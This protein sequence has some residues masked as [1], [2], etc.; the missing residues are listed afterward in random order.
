MSTSRTR[1]AGFAFQ[2]QLLT[3]VWLMKTERKSRNGWSSW[4]PG[5]HTGDLYWVPGSCLPTHP[6]LH[7]HSYLGIKPVLSLISFLHLWK[8]KVYFDTKIFKSTHITSSQKF[9]EGPAVWGSGLKP[10]PAARTQ[11]GTPMGCPC[12]RQRLLPLNRAD[13]IS[14][15]E[16]PSY[17]SLWTWWEL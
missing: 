16:V 6:S 11:T 9:M 5:T 2:V 15:C 14:L 10:W 3:C 7:H 8:K 13:Q 1:V 4:V 17:L 12:C